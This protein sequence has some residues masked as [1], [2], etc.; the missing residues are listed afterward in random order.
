MDMSRDTGIAMATD[1]AT[2]APVVMTYAVPMMVPEII[3][4]GL[5]APMA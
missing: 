4:G 5:L 1:D 3:S 2:S